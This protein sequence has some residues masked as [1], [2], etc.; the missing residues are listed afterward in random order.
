MRP[1]GPRFFVSFFLR[2]IIQ[3]NPQASEAYAELRKKVLV[4]KQRQQVEGQLCSL[5]RISGDHQLSPKVRGASCGRGG[6]GASEEHA[7]LPSTRE[8]MSDR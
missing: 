6:G 5:L 2:C 3:S 7:Y 8:V 4:K 1:C